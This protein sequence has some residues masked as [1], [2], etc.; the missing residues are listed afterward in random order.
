MPAQPR[1]DGS[2]RLL[3]EGGAACGGGA[4]FRIVW[5]RGPRRTDDHLAHN[6]KGGSSRRGRWESQFQSGVFNA[7]R[8]CL[9]FQLQTA[10]KRSSD[11]RALSA[12]GCGE[13]APQRPITFW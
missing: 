7:A 8:A 4:I 9:A 12:W 10:S 13:S 6:A 3:A 11:D 5:T 1:S 2:Y